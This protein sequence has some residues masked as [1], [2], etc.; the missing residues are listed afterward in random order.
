VKNRFADWRNTILSMT[1][2]PHAC[3]QEGLLLQQAVKR[4]WMLK[5]ENLQSWYEAWTD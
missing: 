5:A 4:S 3:R 2:D 1:S